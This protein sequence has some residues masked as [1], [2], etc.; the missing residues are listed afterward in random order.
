[1]SGSAYNVVQ[2]A[3]IGSITFVEPGVR[4]AVPSEA[5]A[6][7]RPF[8]DREAELASMRALVAVPDRLG[9]E[10]VSIWGINGVG[11]TSLAH[12]F[13][14]TSKDLFA[15]GVLSVTFDP[16]ERSPSEA[17]SRLLLGLGVP[18]QRIP[19]TFDK[20]VALFRSMS[21][22][23]RLLVLLDDV[24]DAGQVSALLPNSPTSMVV[25]ASNRALADLYVEGATEIPLRSL[26]VDDGIRLL[27]EMCG[28]ERVAAEPVA[29]R[30]LVEAYEGLPLAIRVAGSLVK[31]SGRSIA[32]LVDELRGVDS[33]RVLNKVFETFDEAY[34]DLPIPLR[35]LYRV[36]GV[37]VGARFG[38]EVVAAMTER[39][40]RRVRT[41]LDELVQAG[42]V[43]EGDPGTYRLHRLVRRHALTRSAEEDGDQERRAL[44][45][46]AVRW[47]LFGAM[48][49]D[50]AAD[51]D[52][53]RVPDAESVR[54]ERSAGVSA[55]A[56]VD[57]LD[58]E[59]ANLLDVMLAA[60]EDGWHAEVCRLFEALFALYKT[61]KPLSAWVRAG[62]LA[63]TSAVATG[64]PETEARCRCLLAKAFQEL[65]RYDEADAE[66]AR[67]REL[68]ADGPDRFTASTYDFT[69]NLCLRQGD[70]AAAL[71]W[72]EQALAI[73]RRLGLV[74]GTALQSTLAA[75]ALGALGRFDEALDLLTTARDLVTGGSAAALLPKILARTG[76]VLTAAGRTEESERTL[77][78]AVKQAEAFG[79]TADAT[80]A[81]ITLA[82]SGVPRAAE[83]RRRAIQL[84]ERMG[85]PRAAR[86]VAGGD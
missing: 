4:P 65:E 6:P 19:S 48:T 71:G 29:A 80:D 10:V 8:V 46:R 77:L 68:V 62:T 64:R 17:A 30:E 73:N 21:A 3:H 14:A 59:H 20:R 36:L 70:P 78:E 15:D 24:T 12:Q 74:R 63:V 43:E 44:R 39:P 28:A 33:D 47:W 35:A 5:G 85:S 55:A 27:G 45:R 49:A 51:P 83:Y 57:W 32:A 37:V 75:R 13:A 69:G 53:L 72:F 54:G 23:L 41:D 42:L 52:R 66:L 18:E 40:V 67:A 34:D 58:R 2:A 31:R 38:A 56:G 84:L 50:L 9:P 7:P 16:H 25:A 60:E 22:D 76:E 26:P 1:M 11:K 86:L 82:E 61:R 79:N 81:L